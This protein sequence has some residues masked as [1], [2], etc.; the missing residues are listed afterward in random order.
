MKYNNLLKLL[1]LVVAFVLS[2]AAVMPVSANTTAALPSF[3]RFVGAVKNGQP[4]VVRGVYVPGVLALR[5]RQQPAN[6]PG[7]VSA[8]A[9]VTTQFQ[10]A[11]DYGVTGL[12]AHNY[13]AGSTFSALAVG[14]EVRVVYGDGSVKKYV[15]TEISKYQAL[16]PN[17][18]YGDLLDLKTGVTNSAGD[19]F[20]KMYTGGDHV[21][22][23]TCIY[24]D[25]NWSWGRLFV[26]AQPVE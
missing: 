13:A 4:G 10:Y 9:N 20:A 12:L 2:F 19:V 5:V 8:V 3:E 11:A 18:P 21:T 6:N 25:G 24:Q 17:N 1:A 7:Y 14:Q 16:D 22:F 26:V 23:Q 15:V